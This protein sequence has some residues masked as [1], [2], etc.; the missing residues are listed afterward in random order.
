MNDFKY[1]LYLTCLN[2]KESSDNVGYM[3]QPFAM[4]IIREDWLY[5]MGII[6]RARAYR[7]V[8]DSVPAGPTSQQRNNSFFFRMKH[9]DCRNFVLIQSGD[10]STNVLL[11]KRD[12]RCFHEFC[13]N[14]VSHVYINNSDPYLNVYACRKHMV[15]PG[16]WDDTFQHLAI[17]KTSIFS[18]VVRTRNLH[19][20][21]NEEIKE[22][23]FNPKNIDIF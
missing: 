22:N 18:Q 19:K 17:G 2:C 3:N 21:S 10:K 5:D 1:Y 20:A 11:H 15:T 23:Y 8:F 7:M 6:H 14:S 16:L 4:D 13:G 9:D 12:T